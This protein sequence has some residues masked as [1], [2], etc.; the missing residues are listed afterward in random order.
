MVV[1]MPGMFLNCW[2]RA[3]T[4]VAPNRLS[5][6]G[7]GLAAPNGRCRIA[8]DAVPRSDSCPGYFPMDASLKPI[9]MSGDINRATGLRIESVETI[10]ARINGGPTGAPSRQQAVL[11][12]YNGGAPLDSNGSQR[13]DR[14]SW[15]PAAGALFD[16]GSR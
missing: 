6:C 9:V 15:Q 3:C 11:T 4:G 13:G 10:A 8:S 12:Q 7:A 1:N 16:A 2:S 5:G 14:L